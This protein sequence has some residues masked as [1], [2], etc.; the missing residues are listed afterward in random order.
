MNEQIY[1]VNVKGGRAMAYQFEDGAGTKYR[2]LVPM[3]KTK[4]GKTPPVRRETFTG[5][6]WTQSLNRGWRKVVSY[7]ITKVGK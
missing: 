4:D 1:S 3:F 5:T 2:A 7:V 6:S